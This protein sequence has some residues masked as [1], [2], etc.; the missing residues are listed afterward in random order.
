MKA[1]K[2]LRLLDISL[3][4]KILSSFPNPQYG[5]KG[6]REILGIRGRPILATVPKPKVGLSPEETAE[7]AYQIWINGID[8]LKDDENLSS[9]RFS[10]FEE[11]LRLVMRALERAEKET[12]E[13]KGYLVNVTAETREMLRRAEL[14]KDY[15]NRFVMLDLLTAG[16]AAAQ[17]LREECGE[18]G[19][20]IHAHRAFHAAFTR[21]PRHG[22]SMLVVAKLARML[23]VDHI[24]VGAVFG[25]LE[26]K[27]S[28]VE[29]IV[30]NLRSSQIRG[31][32][33]HLPQ[34]WG[35]VKP[36][37]PVS[38]GGLHPGLIPKVTK[39]FGRDLLIQVGGGVWGHPRGGGA[40]AK[41]VRQAVEAAVEEIPLREYAKTRPE[42][43]EALKIWG[44]RTYV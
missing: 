17:T 30:E 6:V 13:R 1:V 31:G 19:L 11:R 38:S 27:K 33:T 23:G 39:T 14:V 12:G 32:K 21:N 42:L 22:M 16:W 40:G 2:A 5:I 41:A 20:A 25:K 29:V 44:M 28:E 43:R 36:V 10:R 4:S 3:P 8:L 37:F 9:H 34:S 18:L 24:H 7:L 35:D 15:G 26:A